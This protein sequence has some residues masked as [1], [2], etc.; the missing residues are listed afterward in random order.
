MAYKTFES[1][2]DELPTTKSRE[3]ASIKT[4]I[5]G[6]SAVISLIGYVC[7]YRYKTIYLAIYLSRVVVM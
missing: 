5:S 1:T 7:K 4:S 3:D 2:K 6:K